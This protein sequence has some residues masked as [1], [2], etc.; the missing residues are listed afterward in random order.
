MSV[1]EMEFKDEVCWKPLSTEQSLGELLRGLGRHK[2]ELGL[3]FEKNLAGS[4]AR[5]WKFAADYNDRRKMV[6]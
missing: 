4:L 2:V 5:I 6:Q 1:S 3:V